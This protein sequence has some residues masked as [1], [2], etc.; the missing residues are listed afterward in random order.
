MVAQR[1]A[2]DYNKL[3]FILLLGAVFYNEFFVYYSSYNKWPSL[4]NS[5]DCI[6]ILFVADPQIQGLKYERPFPIGAITR[7]DSDRYLSKT[8]SWAVFAYSPQI[9]VFLG[10]LIDEGKNIKNG[11]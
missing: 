7:W 10:D 8:Y 5:D 2:L 4:S 9:V 11:C 6:K 1:A 3:G